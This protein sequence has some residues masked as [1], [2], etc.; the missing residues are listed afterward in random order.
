M[1]LLAKIPILGGR[2]VW[3]APV[4]TCGEDLEYHMQLF[5]AIK[6]KANTK[7]NESINRIRKYVGV[8]VLMASQMHN[9]LWYLVSYC[10]QFEGP[11]QIVLVLVKISAYMWILNRPHIPKEIRKNTKAAVWLPCPW[12]FHHTYRVL[13]VVAGP[14]HP[15]WRPRCPRPPASTF[16]RYWGMR[17]HWSSHTLVPGTTACQCRLE[18]YIV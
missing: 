9:N 8:W 11:S 15:W 3:V 5:F 18:R 1:N 4:Q 16:G 10:G 12:Q 14:L 17:W 13:A 6:H 7:G 2:T